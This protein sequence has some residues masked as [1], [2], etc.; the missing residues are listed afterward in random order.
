MPGR[1]VPGGWQ[2]FL[3][4][5]P[6]VLASVH[7]HSRTAGP[8]TAEASSDPLRWPGTVCELQLNRFCTGP[9]IPW[10]E[11]RPLLIAFCSYDHE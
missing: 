3:V 9:P 2:V 8:V 1:I 6:R 5:G 11:G 4:G 10:L 7:V